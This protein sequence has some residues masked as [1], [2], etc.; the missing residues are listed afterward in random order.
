MKLTAEITEDA[1]DAEG[2]QGEFQTSVHSERV[3]AK[4]GPSRCRSSASSVSSAFSAVMAVATVCWSFAGAA[5]CCP[6]RGARRARHRG[7][8]SAEPRKREQ[9]PA[10]QRAQRADRSI[11]WPQRRRTPSEFARASRPI[12]LRSPRCAR[13]STAAHPPRKSPA[14]CARRQAWPPAGDRDAAAH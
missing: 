12:S 11:S 6:W 13:R 3:R 10:F 14:S 2:G 8:S 1:E 9:A 4:I 7:A 5:A